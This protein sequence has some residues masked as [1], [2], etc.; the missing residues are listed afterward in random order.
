MHLLAL[1]CEQIT[2]RDRRAC[3]LYSHQVGRSAESARATSLMPYQRAGSSALRN[4]IYFFK[5]RC[6]PI[7]RRFDFPPSSASHRCTGW[8]ARHHG[9]PMQ[10]LPPLSAAGLLRRIALHQPSHRL[11]L[12]R[13]KRRL[14]RSESWKTR[15]LMNL[16]AQIFL[17]ESAVGQCVESRPN[18]EPYFLQL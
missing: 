11:Q 7:I 3:S 16:I 1:H 13:F 9:Q 4:K 18:H 17:T 5:P 14:L 15:V 12:R 10:G 8:P 2:L 6:A